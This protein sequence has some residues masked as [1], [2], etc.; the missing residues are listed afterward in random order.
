MADT[1]AKRHRESQ[2]RKKREIK[3]ERKRLRGEGLLGQDDS[4]LFPP[5]APRRETTPAGGGAKAVPPQEGGQPE[6][7]PAEP[8]DKNDSKT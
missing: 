8:G 6:E 1:P 2:K 7:S 3:A 5:G 4:G